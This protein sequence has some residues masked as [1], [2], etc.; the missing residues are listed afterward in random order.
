[1]RVIKKNL[2]FFSLLF[3]LQ[4]QAQE[5]Q[6]VNP[7]DF[8]KPVYNKIRNFI[9]LEHCGYQII[10]S[11]SGN[12]NL[13]SEP[14][15]V[16]ILEKKVDSLTLLSDEFAVT[17]RVIFFTVNNNTF[18][19]AAVNDDIIDCSHCGGGGVGDPY[20]QPVIDSGIIVFNSLY[21]GCD[22]TSIDISFKYNPRIDNWQLNEITRS[23]YN[24]NDV[25][26][27][28]DINV[29]IE[30]KTPLDFGSVLFAEY[31]VIEE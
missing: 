1:M 18:K 22:K 23:D 6:A 14:D 21:G 29:R 5:D 28:G 12:L 17:R 19:A 13:D 8:E 24:C 30:T 7:L 10:D 2:L 31:P 26:E 11:I 4:A 25:S 3:C 9:F 15:Y 20:Y 27:D 16:I